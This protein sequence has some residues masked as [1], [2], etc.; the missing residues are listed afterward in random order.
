MSN[1]ISDF[2]VTSSPQ[3]PKRMSMSIA[4]VKCCHHLVFIQTFIFQHFLSQFELQHQ[5]DRSWITD[6]VFGLFAQCHSG[7]E[8]HTELVICTIGLDINLEIVVREVQS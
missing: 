3:N 1:N 7:C 8:V 6:E 4:S 2:N 5:T